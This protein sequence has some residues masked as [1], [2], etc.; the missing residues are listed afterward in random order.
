LENLG[1]V[2]RG[3]EYDQNMLYVQKIKLKNK[4]F[5]CGSENFAEKKEERI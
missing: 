4:Q 1:R 5:L 3:K 2:G